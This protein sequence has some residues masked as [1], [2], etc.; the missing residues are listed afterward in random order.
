M[1][2]AI[3]LCIDINQ[4]GNNN[5]PYSI[6]APEQGLTL[7]NEKEELDGIVASSNTN[8]EHGQMCPDEHEDGALIRNDTSDGM[9]V[10]VISE[11]EDS[12]SMMTRTYSSPSNTAEDVIL[13]AQ[14]WKTTVQQLEMR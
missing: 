4:R 3:S 6:D 13:N 9:E 12:S 5:A 1:M 2:Q 11:E 8:V 10:D 7:N 14:R